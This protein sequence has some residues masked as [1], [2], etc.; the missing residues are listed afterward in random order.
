MLTDD[1]P[2][3]PLP[4]WSIRPSAVE[5][6]GSADDVLP[7]FAV[8]DEDPLEAKVCVPE[9]PA[10]EFRPY[11][12]AAAFD[13]FLSLGDIPKREEVRDMPEDRRPL[14]LNCVAVFDLEVP[15]EEAE[16]ERT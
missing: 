15:E 5:A 6:N 14:P 1:P 2:I 11:T 10:T 8:E 4:A 3:P 7:L 12:R 13:S 16:E 9:A